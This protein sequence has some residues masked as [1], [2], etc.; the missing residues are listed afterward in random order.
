M[1]RFL[2]IFLLIAAFSA[3]AKDPKVGKISCSFDN[4]HLFVA[5]SLSDGF[6]T[7][8]VLDA[9]NST[10]PTT[11]TY[12]V[13]VAKKR[14][15]WLD[16]TIVRR[17]VEKTVTY[18]NLTRQYDLVTA[19]DGEEKEKI[20]LTSIEEVGESLKGLADLDMGSVVDLSP[21]EKA[22]Y[23]RVRVTLLKN[24]VLWIIPSDEDTGWMEKELKTP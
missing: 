2:A 5:F 21:G 23:I 8:D 24:F 3:Q 12:E 17:V 9:I 22:Y 10:K 18:D 20:S 11:F 13:E 15:G 7:Q 19:I 4:L 1:R 16:K 6:L 14:I